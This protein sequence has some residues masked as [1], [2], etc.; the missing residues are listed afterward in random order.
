MFILQKQPVAE[1]C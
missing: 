1:Q